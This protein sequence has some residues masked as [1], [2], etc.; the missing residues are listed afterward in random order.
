MDN[1]RAITATVRYNDEE[2]IIRSDGGGSIEAFVNALRKDLGVSCRVLDYHE[3]S[4]GAGAD[5]QAVCYVELEVGER[6]LWGVGINTDTTTASLQAI[7]SGIN[8]AS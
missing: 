5:A 8:R 4:I 1:R 3:H 6:T 2:N 7:I